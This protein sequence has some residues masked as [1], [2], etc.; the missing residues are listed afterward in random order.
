MHVAASVSEKVG[1]FFDQRAR[2]FHRIYE[3]TPILERTFNRVLRRAMY[4][5]SEVLVDEVRRLSAPTLLDVGSGT[6][7][8]TFAALRAGASHATGLDLAST[9][10]SM[11]RQGA[12]EQGLSERCR[13]DE[14]DFMTWQD[15]S[16]F[17]VV[18]A[19]GVFDYV[20]DSEVFLR[21]MCAVGN[22][23]VVASFPGRGVRG[24]LRRVRYE[25]QGCPLF[26]FDEDEVRSWATA[27]DYRDVSFPF[28]D[29]S[30]F[31]LVARR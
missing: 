28:R 30:G 14:G 3:H 7:V 24:Q 22:R 17:D 11:A 13:F 20:K 26:L 8:N 1:R 5:R 19:L 21:R 27:E 9:M 15:G 10:V 29:S 25:A 4:A 16:R 18:A 6:G 2:T 31:V 12:A 23:S